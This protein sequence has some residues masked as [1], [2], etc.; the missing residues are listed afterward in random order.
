M[1]GIAHRFSVRSS[2][3]VSIYLTLTAIFDAAKI[4][5]YFARNDTHGLAYASIVA[6]VIKGILL[7]LEEIPKR[8]SIANESV[9]NSVGNET[10]S[11]FCRGPFLCGSMSYYSLDTART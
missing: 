10:V 4:R 6:A 7:I 3:L 11:G 2:A 8:S 9:R 1:V 5:S